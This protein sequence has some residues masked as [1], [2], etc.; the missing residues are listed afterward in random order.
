VTGNILDQARA[1]LPGVEWPAVVEGP[2]ATVLALARQLEASQWLDA[3]TLS[4]RQFAQLG[5]LLPWL[6][7]HSPAFARRL[8]AA[9][10]NAAALSS[11][12]AFAALPPVERRWFQLEEGVYCDAVPPGHE[13]VGENVT[14][15]S[16]GEFLRIRRTRA[17][18]LVWLA[19][20][21]RDHAWRATDFSVPLTSVRAPNVGIKEFPDWGPP[22]SWLFPTGPALSLPTKLPGHELYD[23]MTA[24]GTGNL[25]IYPNALGTV[26]DEAD[27][28]GKPLETLKAVR[29]VGEMVSEHLRE[30]T[31]EVLGLEIA[32]AYTCQEVGYVALQCP[33]SGL[34]HF[35][36]EALIVEV[37]RDDGSP[38]AEGEI[39]RVVITDI[40]NHATPV[41]RYALGDMAEASAPCPCGRGLPA[42][43]RIVG[44]SRNLI[45]LPTGDRV[46]PSLGGFGP[47][48]YLK[49]LPILQFQLRQTELDLL[50]V[51]LVTGRPLTAEEEQLIVERARRAIGHP[52]RLEFRYFEGRLPLPDSGK[53]EDFI[54][55]V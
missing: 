24:F 45:R 19:M 10:M 7:D 51:R 2:A 35:M 30:R 53:F 47:E 17:N 23:R 12:E 40:H 44:R 15:G 49:R 18:Q 31:R 3:A 29:T 9:G 26:V 14:S 34:Y 52:F 20:V 48:G 46:W 39:G 28:R 33:Q 21:L 11:S 50:E 32:D 41:V 25:V 42:V 13:P 4:R 55:L 1:S 36:A 6:A 5:H 22:A 16:T 43:R 37:L 38:C 54:C 27:R 8:Q